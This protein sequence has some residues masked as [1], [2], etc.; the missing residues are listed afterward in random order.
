MPI[1]TTAGNLLVVYCMNGGNNTATVTISDSAGQSWTQTTSGYA[2]SAS[3]NRSAMFYR[4]N[5]A[6]VTSIT[7][8]WTASANNIGAIVYE[9]SGADIS[10]PADGSVNSSLSGSGI[11]SLTSGSPTTTNANDILIYGARSQND[12]TTWTAGTGYTIPANGSNTRQGTQFKVVTSTQSG[13]TTTM[14]WNTGT[15]GAAGIFA[16]FKAASGGGGGTGP[17]ITN[18]NPASGAVGTM[19]TITG[20]NFGTSQGSS[21]VTFNGITAGTGS[22]WSATSIAIKVPAGAT[23]GSVVVTVGGVP[24]NGVSFTVTD[25]PPSISGLNP[26]SGAISTSVTISGTYFGATKGSNTVTFNGTMATPTSWSNTSIVI[27]VPSGATTG[28]VVVTVSGVTSNGMNFTVTDPAPNISG[29]N[30]VSGAVGASVTITGTNFGTSQG[31]STVTFNGISAG[32][33]SNWSATS[34]G[35]NVPAGATTGEVGVTVAGA[36][37]NG[38]PFT[39]TGGT[40]KLPIKASSNNRYLVDQ[41]NVPWLMVGDSGHNAICNLAT[42]N[43]PSYLQDR[44]SQGFNTVY[45]FAMNAVS[46]CAHGAAGQAQDGTAPF[47]TGSGPATYDVST[48]NGAYWSE[49]D[50]FISEGASHGL[51]VVINP[52]PWGDGF[53]STYQNNGTSKIFNLGAFLGAR[54]KN[55]TDIIWSVGQDFNANSFPSSSDLNLMA[56]LMA[57]IASADPN[58]LINC[59]LNYSRSYSTQANSSNATYAQYLT[60]N[61]VYTYYEVYDYILAAHNSSPTLPVFLGESNYE[62]ANNTGQLSGAAN[63]FIT[64]QEMWYAMTSGATGH[65][66]GNEHIN[67]FDSSYLSNLDTTATAQV[68]YLPSLFAQS[69]WWTFSPDQTH[70]LVTSGYGTYDGGNGNMYNATYAPTTWDG[71]SYSLTYTPVS[72]TLLVDLG[73]F[74]KSVT[75][76][77]Y[78]P[79]TGTFTVISG[80]PFANSGSQNFSTPSTAHGDGTHDWVLVF[81]P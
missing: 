20:T 35:V 28:N 72:T 9:I 52:M 54:Y 15:V 70:K 74:T 14:S 59:Q 33:A 22:S 13:V 3:T 1:N 17:S 53:S 16:A 11:T 46:S 41:N 31:S 25:P 32:T 65:I 75:A 47:T 45:I 63:D 6:A 77:W 71:A 64:R 34:I 19:V 67:H 43:W 2:S 79:T 7:A 49:V 38:V 5:S 8:T 55:T 26:A 44:Q 58:H 42:S 27:P 29:L 37:S 48:P 50:S 73:M 36:V 30:P 51:V 66:F 18:L 76:E 12:E 80:S 60:S 68:K 39:V 61:F 4:A 23:T 10:S 62:T 24:S 69:P 81:H 40:V 57:G 78:D 21:T 56:Q